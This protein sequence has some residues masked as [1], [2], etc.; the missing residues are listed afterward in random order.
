MSLIN[1]QKR[2]EVVRQFHEEASGAFSDLDKLI[3]LLNQRKTNLMTVRDQGQALF[4]AGVMTTEEV[5]EIQA[6]VDKVGGWLTK[7]NQIKA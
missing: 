6:W 1:E 5:G 2:R 4:D 3:R 7:A